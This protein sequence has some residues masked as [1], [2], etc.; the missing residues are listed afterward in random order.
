MRAWGLGFSGAAGV[1]GVAPRKSNLHGHLCAVSQTA[2][3][4]VWVQRG[5]A[6][7]V[8]DDE[9]DKETELLTEATVAWAVRNAPARGEELLDKLPEEQAARIRAIAARVPWM[10]QAKARFMTQERCCQNSLCSDVACTENRGPE[11]TRDPILAGEGSQGFQGHS[12]QG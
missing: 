4:G 8:P 3:A 9:F 7:P 12:F 10:K 5:A 2:T 11:N 6:I 1:E